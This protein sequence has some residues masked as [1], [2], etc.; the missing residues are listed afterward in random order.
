M[1]PFDTITLD[2]ETW[3]VA[4]VGGNLAVSKGAAAVAQDMST[5]VRLFRGEYCYNAL[6]GVPY[7]SIFG[8]ITSLPILKSDIA[9]AAAAVPGAENVVC[10]IESVKERCV[11]GQVQASVQTA[12]GAAAVAASISGNVPFLILAPTLTGGGGFPILTGGPGGP[13]L[14][15]GP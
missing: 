3:D 2:A 9:T 15:G 13:D 7:L 14:T 1:A 5:A 10:Y 6:V 4:V 12:A 11:S 8:Q